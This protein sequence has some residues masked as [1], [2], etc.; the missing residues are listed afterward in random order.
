MLA[1]LQRR[2]GAIPALAVVDTLD[3]SCVGVPLL[4][5]GDRLL[6][7]ADV[8]GPGPDDTNLRTI[9][10]SAPEGGPIRVLFVDDDNVLREVLKRE[11]EE[12]GLSLSA[13]NA[14]GKCGP[15]GGEAQIS[16]PT[17]TAST[18]TAAAGA[19]SVEQSGESDVRVYGG[20]LSA[21]TKAGETIQLTENEAVRI[22]Q[23]G[24]A[25]AEVRLPAAPAL[26]S[27]AN[28]SEVVYPDPTRAITL[29]AWKPV[30]EAV[31]YQVLLDYSPHF[32]R[33]LVDR[34]GIK[35]SSVEVRGLDLGKYYWRVAAVD[36]D[37]VTGR[38]SDFSRFTVARLRSSSSVPSTLAASKAPMPCIHCGVSSDASSAGAP[39][40]PA[41]DSRPAPRA[42]ARSSAAES[43]PSSIGRSQLS[44]RAGLA[45]LLGPAWGADDRVVGFGVLS[46]G[47][48][49]AL[50]SAWVG[51]RI[52]GRSAA[53]CVLG[54]AAGGDALRHETTMRGSAGASRA[55]R[56]N[57][58]IGGCAVIVSVA[59]G[60]SNHSSSRAR[61][62]GAAP[63]AGASP[64]GIEAAGAALV[65]RRCCTSE[66]PT[67]LFD[68]SSESTSESNMK[69]PP[70]HHDNV[71]KMVTAWR[72]PITRSV[73]PPPSDASP[74]PWPACSITTTARSRPSIISSV[75][76]NP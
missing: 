3:A 46:R 57:G 15:A 18:D 5:L 74:P 23:A 39:S 35:E 73:V 69:M 38:F 65:L 70:D 17:V 49:P 30:T 50:W 4:A 14:A 51:V 36:K 43:S 33:P 54:A 71:C 31:T 47:E 59:L 32:N 28:L 26:L 9:E 24:N 7:V 60:R 52:G 21:S 16:T 20:R 41:T 63:A 48:M 42:N 25:G 55:L 29:L 67:V 76:I 40:S 37:G 72:P 8:V 27:P 2:P 6:Y 68:A 19:I 66:T 11:L 58:S 13:V 34:G 53:G 1:E 12:F 75:R 64:I 56:S 22:D 45:G 44:G 61:R 62:S 10:A